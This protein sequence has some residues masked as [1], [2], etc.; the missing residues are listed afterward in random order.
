MTLRVLQATLWCVDLTTVT[1]SHVSPQVRKMSQRTLITESLKTNVE[2]G[3]ISYM[4]KSA[5]QP[6]QN[7]ITVPEK[8]IVNTFPVHQHFHGTEADDCC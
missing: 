2:N 1:Q 7:N 3:D 5:M 4:V 8:T 6:L